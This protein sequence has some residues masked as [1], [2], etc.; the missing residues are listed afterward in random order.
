MCEFC[1]F[2]GT[3][4]SQPNEHL[5][6]GLFDPTAA[7]ERAVRQATAARA[8]AAAAAVSTDEHKPSAGQSTDDDDGT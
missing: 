6:F 2:N 4:N 1:S 5:G 7:V 3:D 8:A